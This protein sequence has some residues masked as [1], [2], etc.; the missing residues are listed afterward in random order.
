MLRHLEITTKTS[1]NPLKLIF[2]GVYNIQL[3]ESQYFAK[4]QSIAYFDRPD[5][6]IGFLS[7]Y[8]EH[9]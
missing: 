2:D 1:E 4:T 6:F 8:T 3:S 7:V 9:F 5:R